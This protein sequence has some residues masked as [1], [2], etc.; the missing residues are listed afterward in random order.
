MKTVEDI[1]AA[2]SSLSAAERLQLVEAIRDSLL[3]SPN[4]EATD[5]ELGP[6]DIIVRYRGDDAMKVFVELCQLSKNR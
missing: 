4:A 1:I 3:D 6:D 2:V 5:S